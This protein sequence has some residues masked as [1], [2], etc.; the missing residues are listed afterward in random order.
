MANMYGGW[1]GILK[2]TLAQQDGTT[3]SDFGEM[4]E[5]VRH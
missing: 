3:P 4:S 2:W 1:L 5:E